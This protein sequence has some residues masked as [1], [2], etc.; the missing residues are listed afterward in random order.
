MDKIIAGKLSS[1]W[2]MRHRQVV[3]PQYSRWHLRNWLDPEG[4]IDLVTRN[5]G[6]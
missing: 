5:G 6:Q 2:V 4:D 3:S 1:I